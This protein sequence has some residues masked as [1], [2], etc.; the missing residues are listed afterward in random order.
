MARKLVFAKARS[1]N[2]LGQPFDI[3]HENFPE[4]WVALT[5]ECGRE[6]GVDGDAVKLYGCVALLTLKAT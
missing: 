2:C 3:A 6:I 4:C 1:P 5:I